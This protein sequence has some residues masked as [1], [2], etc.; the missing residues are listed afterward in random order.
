VK[1]RGVFASKIVGE[2]HQSI[3]IKNGSEIEATNKPVIDRDILLSC[4]IEEIHLLM[5]VIGICTTSFLNY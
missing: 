1:H 3:K 5:Q 2:G 4:A